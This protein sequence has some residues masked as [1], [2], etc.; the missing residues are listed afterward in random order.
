[1][2]KSTN[3]VASRNACTFPQRSSQTDQVQLSLT[4]YL[5]AG[6]D[7]PLGCA[8]GGA[9]GSIK[10]AVVVVGAESAVGGL[11]PAVRLAATVMGPTIESQ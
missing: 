8:G 1:M 4:A 11:L 10:V 2:H 6:K 3:R 7:E 5:G 9:V